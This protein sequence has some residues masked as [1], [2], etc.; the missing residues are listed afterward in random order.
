[1]QGEEAKQD[2][3]KFRAK[4]SRKVEIRERALRGKD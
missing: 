2:K 3:Q 1:M 4:N